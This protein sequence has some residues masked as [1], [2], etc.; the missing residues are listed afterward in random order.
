[1]QHWHYWYLLSAAL[2]LLEALALP[3]IGFF[4]AGFGAISTA[5]LLQGG[6]IDDTLLTQATVFCFATA[7]WAAI[8]WVPL[9][10][11]RLGRGK[12]SPH[13][14]LIGRFATVAGEGLAKGHT[15]HAKWS[16]TLFNARLAER[17]SIATAAPGEELKIIDINGSTLIL[18]EADHPITEAS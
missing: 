16:G 7:I 12:P 6:Y 18:A 15:G 8:L 1:M 11:L 4:F 5:L 3:G 2:F 14:D 9:K 10:K 13:H 17:A